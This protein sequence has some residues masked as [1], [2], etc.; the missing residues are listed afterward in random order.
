VRE[1]ARSAGEG[2]TVDAVT[3]QYVVER[4]GGSGASSTAFAEPELPPIYRNSY[5]DPR[6]ARPFFAD[7]GRPRFAP[8]LTALCGLHM[9]LPEKCF[10]DDFGARWTWTRAWQH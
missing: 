8:D 10:D 9:S 2:A 5:G 4:A 7:H 3:A 6:L 1:V